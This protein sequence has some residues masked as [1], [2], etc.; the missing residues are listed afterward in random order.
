MHFVLQLC[1]VMAFSS[2]SRPLDFLSFLTR[3]LTAFSLH[4]SSPSA[5]F[6]P[7]SRLIIGGLKLG[8]MEVII[9]AGRTCSGPHWATYYVYTLLPPICEENFKRTIEY[10]SYTVPGG[11]KA[12]HT[13]TRK[14]DTATNSWATRSRFTSTTHACIYSIYI[15]NFHIQR[16]RIIANLY[17]PAK[18]G[19][20]TGDP[21]S[22]GS[23]ELVALDPGDAT[24][25][26]PWLTR[27]LERVLPRII[28]KNPN[29]HTIHLLVAAAAIFSHSDSCGFAFSR[30]HSAATAHTLIVVVG[31]LRLLLSYRRT[32][33]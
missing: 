21:G 3:L 2:S 10:Y 8:S 30:T 12:K 27:S 5:F 26:L 14:M 20:L 24:I 13:T 32:L 1:V 16:E 9:C 17:K 23:R 22:S 18:L 11:A 19:A 15:I 31:N 6:Q 7:N 25:V 4:L 33:W 29:E 28:R